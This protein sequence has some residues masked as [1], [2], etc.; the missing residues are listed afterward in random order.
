[1]TVQHPHATDIMHWH[2]RQSPQSSGRITASE[3]QKDNVVLQKN[4]KD[5]G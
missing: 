3:V 1:M 2:D 5:L 4:L